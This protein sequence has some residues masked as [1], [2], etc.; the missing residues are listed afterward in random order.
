MENSKQPKQE[1]M[2]SCGCVVFDL[3]SKNCRL[4][5][6]PEM[7]RGSLG[8]KGLSY[9]KGKLKAIKTS[10]FSKFL[11]FA[12]TGYDYVVVSNFVRS[13]DWLKVFAAL[14]SISNDDVVFN[15]SCDWK[16]VDSTVEFLSRVDGF[17]PFQRGCKL[18]SAT[19]IQDGKYHTHNGAM[20]FFSQRI[21]DNIHK[22]GYK[23]TESLWDQRWLKQFASK[24]VMEF[25]ANTSRFAHSAAERNVR[26][27][28]HTKHHSVFRSA[29]DEYYRSLMSEYGVRPSEA[30]LFNNDS[31]KKDNKT[32]VQLTKVLA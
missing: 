28:I 5:G 30:G 11:K 17:P 15:V 21:I 14:N 6:L 8:R 2:Y 4:H 13:D 16:E 1:V 12:K 19:S 29:T 27:L 26:C 23:G 7:C 25:N 24:Q 22:V 3:D 31:N 20:L 9:K 10:K 32:Q 18:V